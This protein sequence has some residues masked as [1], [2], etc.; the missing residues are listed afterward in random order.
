MKDSVRRK[1]STEA[2]KVIKDNL[3]SKVLTFSPQINTCYNDGINSLKDSNFLNRNEEVLFFRLQYHKI[4][5]N[6]ISK[7]VQEHDNKI[8]DECTFNPKIL[9]TNS[10]VAKKSVSIRLYE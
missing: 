1:K 4:N 5:N 6:K 3:E 9:K 7:I 10:I 8:K 2:K